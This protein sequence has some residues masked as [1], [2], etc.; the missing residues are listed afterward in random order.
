M[1][2]FNLDLRPSYTN[3]TVFIR[4]HYRVLGRVEL[5]AFVV[6]VAGRGVAQLLGT[7]TCL[8]ILLIQILS[9]F[10][11]FPLCE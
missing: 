4:V 11:P 9:H 6:Q 1:G 3:R 2:R 8:S 10:V 5:E 7:L